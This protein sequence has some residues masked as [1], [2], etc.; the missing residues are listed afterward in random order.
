MARIRK[1]V[2]YR[3]LERPNTRISK[4]RKK[5][6]IKVR[7]SSKIVKFAIGNLVK[8]FEYK[9]LLV[10]KTDLQIRH[11]ALE[12]ARQ[13]GNRHLELTIG[14]TNYRLL[15]RKYP[16]HILRENPL[17]A[18]AGADR[19]STGMAHSFG[20]PI[21]SAAQ[22]DKGDVVFE[23]DVDK[24]HLDAAKVAVKRCSHKLPN[25]YQIVVEEAKKKPVKAAAKKDAPAKE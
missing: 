21:G 14:K 2:S 5:A 7:P 1:F 15:V 10:S 18:G 23:V 22:V 3:T 4:Y 6:F 12:S 24:A 11:N 19:L 16:H 25:K 8:E 13:T 17:A 20:K 9:V